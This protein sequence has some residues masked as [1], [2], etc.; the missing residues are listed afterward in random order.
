M[1]GELPTPT[2]SNTPAKILRLWGKTSRSP[3]NAGDFHPA[4]YHMLDVG[5]VARVLLG[6]RASPRWRTNLGRNLGTEAEDLLNWL[7]WLISLHDIGKISAPFQEQSPIHRKR[8]FEEGFSFGNR[9]WDNNP[10]HPLIGQYYILKETQG[11]DI[12]IRLGLVLRDA[13][14]GHHGYFAPAG[15]LRETR[16]R[17]R[18]E[19]KEWVEL[20]QAASD[21]LRSQLATADRIAWEDPANV[22]AAIVELTGFTILC[23]WLGSDGSIFS[24]CPDVDLDNYAIL[25]EERARVAT[26]KAGF[27]EPVCSS[28]PVGF[29]DLFPHFSPARPLQL[30]ID[31]ISDEVLVQPCLA[32]I[33]APTGEGKTEAGMALAHRIGQARGTDEFYYAL[34]TTATSNQMF[35][36]VQHYLYQNLQLHTRTKLIHGQ[37]FL[38]EDDLRVQ[39]LWEGIG[40][41]PPPMLEWFSPKKRALLAPFGVGTIDQIELAALNVRHNA[42]RMVGLA[43]K[44]VIIDEVHAYDVYMTTVLKRLLEWF[45]ALGTSV[46]LLSATL[47]KNRRS[48]LMNAY[49]G[50]E[51]RETGEK[52]PYPCVI[53]TGK[54]GQ[55]CMTPAAHQAQ[56]KVGIG[57][58]H[59]GDDEVEEKAAWLLSAVAEGGCACW[60]TNT[61]DRAQQ[62]FLAVNELAGTETNRL[63][64]HARFP[65]E[66]RQQLEKQLT[67]MYGFDKTNRPHR[68]VVIGTQVLE[69]SLDLDF[70]VMVSD[71]APIDLLLQRAGRLHRHEFT[72]RPA[73]HGA[74]VLWINS[75]VSKNGQLRIGVDKYIYAEFILRQSWESLKQLREIVLPGDYRSLVEAVYDIDTS[76]LEG[77]L[78][79]T[80]KDLHNKEIEAALQA[81]V[82]LLP[83]PDPEES[84]CGL[85]AGMHFE[86]SES[87]AGWF[88]AQTRLGQESLTVIP[89]EREGNKAWFYRNGVKTTFPVNEVAPRNLQLDLLRRSVRIGHMQ[90]VRYLREGIE[91]GERLFADAELLK[92]CYPLWLVNGKIALKSGSVNYLI[93]L[94][95]LLGVLIIKENS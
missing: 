35:G 20:R 11:M 78:L 57:H 89:L 61:V 94:D 2:Q 42:L 28:A 75:E 41:A 18:R 51:G 68:G 16:D 3:E 58:L 48:A 74:P 12:P 71:L 43:G 83:W 24:L 69:Q 90:I 34:P 29:C 88:I 81:E 62:M 37:A 53:I 17:L 7:P 6:K 65:L 49:T 66:D 32:V 64:L 30:A 5:M 63:L 50:G 39:P 13:I 56:R 76:T 95:P 22:S 36:R 44:V 26:E 9:T 1:L 59:F 92:E 31:E 85:A 19:P 67:E 87:G 54:Y 86:E 40:Q 70:D 80:W 45:S 52:N 27:L 79:E 38:V 77:A 72:S 10:H 47:P 93:R 4:L 91:K 73:C 14:A 21:I 46:I 60:I 82:R 23:D 84:F 15:A 33:E 25:S 55:H 8:L